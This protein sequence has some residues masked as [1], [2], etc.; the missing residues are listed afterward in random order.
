MNSPRPDEGSSDIGTLTFTHAG[1]KRGY[2]RHSL[3]DG[4]LTFPQFAAGL[5]GVQYAIDVYTPLTYYLSW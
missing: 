3:M 1:P 5:R 4:L 2:E